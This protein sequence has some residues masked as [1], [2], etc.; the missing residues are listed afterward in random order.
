[1]AVSPSYK[2]FVLEQLKV[3]GSVTARSMFGGVGLYLDGVFFGLLDDDAIYLKVD[4]GN[5]GDYEKAGMG[6][7]RPYGDESYAMQYYELPADVLEERE[8]LREWVGKA[9]AAARRKVAGK[10]KRPRA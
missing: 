2:T 4:D 3:V 6:P 10:R 7:F 1:M 8:A 9:L 5:R